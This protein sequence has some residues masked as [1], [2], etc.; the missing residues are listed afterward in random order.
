MNDSSNVLFDLASLDTVKASNDGAEIEIR[1]PLTNAPL[2]MFVTV[3]GKDGDIFRQFQR[4]KFNELLRAEAHAKARGKQT[5]PKSA[6]DY[7]DDMLTMLVRCTKGWR[8][9]IYDKEPLDFTA[10][11]VRMVYKKAPWFRDQINEAVGDLANFM[12]N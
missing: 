9:V 11:N 5:P 8:N 1:H 12:K 2:G 4:E 7:E 10:E 3:V 6:E